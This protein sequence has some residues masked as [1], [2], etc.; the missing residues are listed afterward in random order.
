MKFS[1]DTH[2][3]AV[4]SIAQMMEEKLIDI[5][6]LFTVVQEHQA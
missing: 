5:E 6:N 3:R 4:R 2:N 1:S